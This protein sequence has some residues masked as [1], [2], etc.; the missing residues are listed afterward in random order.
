MEAAAAL[1]YEANAADGALWTAATSGQYDADCNH[2]FGS[3]C[4]A[5]DSETFRPQKPITE[6]AL[7]LGFTGAVEQ[8]EPH[9]PAIGLV[10]LHHRGQIC[11][12]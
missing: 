3:D 10:F 5:I 7:N 8:V 4:D 12:H 1:G 6:A 9:D 2:L 11:D